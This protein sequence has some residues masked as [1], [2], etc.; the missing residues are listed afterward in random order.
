MATEAEVRNALEGVMDPELHK[1][2]I[3][4]GMIRDLRIE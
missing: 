1:S 4:L 2:M 3:E